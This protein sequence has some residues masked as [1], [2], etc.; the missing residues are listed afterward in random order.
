MTIHN[1]LSDQASPAGAAPS[2]ELATGLL[3]KILRQ[4]AGSRNEKTAKWESPLFWK[5]LA[6]GAGLLGASIGA[7]VLIG[8]MLDI[9]ALKSISPN[10][11]AMKANTALCFVLSGL[12]LWLKASDAIHPK[13]LGRAIEQVMSGLVVLLSLLTLFEILAS[14]DLGIDQWLFQEAANAIGTL[15]PGRMAPATALCFVMLGTALLLSSQSPRQRSLITALAVATAIPALASGLIH[16]YDTDNIYGLG[17]LLQLATHTVL[18]L[19]LL[20]LGVLCTQPE[21]GV[22]ALLRRR[23]SGGT[24]IRRLLPITLFLPILLGWLKLVGEH[25]NL[26][27]PDFGVALVALSYIIILSLL[28]VWSARFLSRVDSERGRMNAVIASDDL[29]LRTLLST[30]PDPIWLKDINGV[31]LTCNPAFEHFLGAKKAAIVGK[32]DYDF[33]HRELADFFRANDQSVITSG[34][35]ATNEEWLTL[36]DNGQRILAETT[37]MPMFDQQGKLLGVLGIARDITAHHLAAEQLRNAKIETDHLL[38]ESNQSK[39]AL[40]S[41]LEDSKATTR[42]LQLSQKRYAFLFNAI[43]DA[44]YVHEILE[45]GAPSL[46]LEVNE[47]ACLLSGYTREELL[48]MTPLQLDA[49]DSGVDL[50]PVIQRLMAGESATFEQTHLS[51]NGQRIPVEIHSHLFKLNERPAVISIVR[52]ITERKRAEDV[53]K[54]SEERY[55]TMIENSNDMIWTLTPEGR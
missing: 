28:V 37:K 23:D 42:A 7:L 53:L 13:S 49:P 12:A 30:I 29:Q 14:I 55:R 21:Q 3:E 5:T 31:Y 10:W 1:P 27:E 2:A 50:A 43:A 32:T 9:S 52:D 51:K 34:K 45:S 11:I 19:I 38:A 8:W 18:G 17:Y 24:L 4:Q 36:A 48:G 41:V 35:P 16:L 6:K 47:V 33:V 25:N 40:L 54:N 20:A 46:F 22:V 15:S 39:Q 44:V 26:Y